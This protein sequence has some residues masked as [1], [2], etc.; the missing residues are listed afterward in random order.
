MRRSTLSGLAGVCLLV[1]FVLYVVSNAL[2]SWCV[3]HSLV[4]LVVDR[5]RLFLGVK[6]LMNPPLA[7][8]ERVNT[9]DVYGDAEI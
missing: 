9:L 2:P 1:A 6:D 4:E 5:V 3:V 7:C 8:G